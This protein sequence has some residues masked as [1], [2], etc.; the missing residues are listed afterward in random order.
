V[1]VVA[2]FGAALSGTWMMRRAD[3]IGPGA[4]TQALI[5]GSA[6]PTTRTAC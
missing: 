4:G 3:A 2:A 5:L 1:R 6:N